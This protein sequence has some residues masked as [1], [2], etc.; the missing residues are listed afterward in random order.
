[1]ARLQSVMLGL[2]GLICGI[3]YSFGGLLID[4]LVTLG[5]LSPEAMSTPGLS[6][7]TL[8]AMG[9]LIG[10]P[11]IFAAFGMALGFVEALMFN[12]FSKWLGSIQINLQDRED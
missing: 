7:G 10:M 1:M 3:L 2:I 8:L 11:V 4:A 5:L 12:L 9:A 6:I